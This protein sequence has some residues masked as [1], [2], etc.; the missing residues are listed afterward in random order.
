MRIIFLILAFT[1]AAS[2]ATC[3]A[4]TQAQANTCLTVTMVSG[5]T[6]QI[7]GVGW[8]FSGCSGPF[9][10]C[11]TIPSSLANITIS[12]QA[13][14]PPT[15]VC[16]PNCGAGTPTTVLTG[17]GVA[18]MFAFNATA[19]GAFVFKDIK[20]INTATNTGA[21]SGN[22]DGDLAIDGVYS[23]FRITNVTLSN[24][25]TGGRALNIGK[26]TW[27]SGSPLVLATTGIFGLI[28]HMSFFASGTTNFGSCENGIGLYNGADVDWNNPD[29]FGTTSAFYIE[30]SILDGTACTQHVSAILDGEHGARLVFR[31]LQIK[32]LQIEEHDA[33]TL[34]SRGTRL[35]EAY[36]IAFTCSVADCGF[37]AIQLRGGTGFYYNNTMPVQPG[38]GYENANAT[39]ITRVDSSGFQDPWF[40]QCTCTANCGSITPPPQF[41]CAEHTM[42]SDLQPHCTAGTNP[43]CG[44]NGEAVGH[45]GA[46]GAACSASTCGGGT[47]GFCNLRV[48][49]SGQD[50]CRAGNNLIPFIDGVDTTGG[51]PI[52]NQTGRGLYSPVTSPRNKIAPI[53][54]WNNQ[55]TLHANAQLTALNVNS[56]GGEVA[57]I[58]AN[59]DVYLGIDNANCAPSAATCIAG[60]GQGTDAQR[61]AA[62]SSTTFPGPG[63]FSITT[64]TLFI[65]SDT[66][67]GGCTTAGANFWCS[68]YTSLMYPHPLQ[69]L[70]VISPATLVQE[71]ISQAVNVPFSNSNCGAGSW[72]TSGSFPGGISFNTGSGIMSGTVTAP[73]G[74]FTPS[75]TWSNPVT[76]NNYNVIVNAIPSISTISPLPSGTQGVLYSQTLTIAGGTT[77]VTCVITAGT[78]TNSGLTLSSLCTVS[79]TGGTPGIYNF[80]VTPTDFNNVSGTAKAFQ[81]TIVASGSLGGTQTGGNALTGGATKLN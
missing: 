16:P 80:T 48:A 76:T 35:V 47:C 39:Q 49:T 74:T 58:R 61:P 42:C 30:D 45:D 33:S 5:D 77:P 57:F 51:Y 79:G 14:A 56:A 36:N 55:D 15:G 25:N 50:I 29:R 28:D 75:V 72:S 26:N 13:A 41:S 60:V 70:C 63:Y 66:N 32:D 24:T 53:Y 71:T 23:S 11:I 3:V 54:W 67:L 6:L 18:P 81:V 38:N 9:T 52:I 59:R 2:A 40:W 27:I 12:G 7:N 62:C 22:E 73:T 31:H 37:Q 8:T 44:A 21:A 19:G 34:L 20:L 69:A 4:T 46:N 17:D 1:L 65:C 78:L 68:Y 43:L 10:A 64:N